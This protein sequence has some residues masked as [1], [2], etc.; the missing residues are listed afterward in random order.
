MA[1]IDSAGSVYV[2]GV[3]DGTAFGVAGTP[4][5]DFLAKYSSTGTL[6]WNHEWQDTSGSSVNVATDGS[7]NVWVTSGAGVQN[8]NSGGGLA[9]TAAYASGA[10]CGGL[11]LDPSGNAYITGAIYDAAGH[12]KENPFVS[13]YSSTGS[14]LWTRE[15]MNPMPQ[16]YSNA[17]AV[18]S[19][20]QAAIL[21]TALDSK[22]NPQA[23]A[24]QFDA[25]GNIV[26]NQ[27]YGQGWAGS[28]AIDNSGSTYMTLDASANIFGSSG[29][30]YLV[31]YDS[32]NSLLW[33][34][35]FS[36]E[37]NPMAI[38][39]DPNG[40]E[41]VNGGSGVLKYSTSGT[42]LDSYS[43]SSYYISSLAYSNGRMAI[44]D[45]ANYSCTVSDVIVPEPGSLLM[46]AA[47]AFSLA[48]WAAIVRARK[49]P[50]GACGGRDLQPLQNLVAF[51]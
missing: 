45:S 26:W 15:V 35:Q 32:A 9:W 28:I 40:F 2:G 20:G 47:A 41:Y 48:G 12:Y 46:L 4:E 39:I 19:L 36:R 50:D 22:Y 8:Y 6:L 31:K 34:S 51:S 43:W 38:T 27:T 10:E 30:D 29:G 33:Y 13:K 37:N 23:F 44:A 16:A 21:G 3:T 5:V 17:I 42:L 18:N 24:T 49:R 14:R 7:G 25:T 11:A 1:A